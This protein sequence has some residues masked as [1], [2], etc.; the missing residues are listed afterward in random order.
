MRLVKKINRRSGSIFLAL[1]L[2][3]T[4]FSNVS[5]NKSE[6]ATNASMSAS[7]NGS[8]VTF[9]VSLTGSN[10]YTIVQGSSSSYT[11]TIYFKTISAGVFT[12]GD[13]ST[14][15]YATVSDNFGYSYSTSAANT[16]QITL[17]AVGGS[18]YNGTF[19]FTANETSPTVGGANVSVVNGSCSNI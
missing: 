6:T 8:Q 15:Y 17:T 13:Q 11:M 7:L 16:G 9:T 5:C 3:V 10:G 14:G 19:Y 2:F 12:L 18:R 1:I 4:M